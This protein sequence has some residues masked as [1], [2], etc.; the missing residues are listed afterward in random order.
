ML[1]SVLFHKSFAPL[2][3]ITHEIGEIGVSI[4][5]SLPAEAIS[6][7]IH[8]PQ[9]SDFYWQAIGPSALK[10]TIERENGHCFKVALCGHFDLKTTCVRCLNPLTMPITIDFS[11]R[12]IEKEHLGFM[13]EP[14]TIGEDGALEIDMSKDE[15]DVVGYFAGT[16]IDV[17]LILRDQIFLE[18]PDYPQCASTRCSLP[19]GNI[20]G[21]DG[22]DRHDGY[23]NNPFVKLFKKT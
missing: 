21:A 4:D 23:G 10:G 3:F 2:R 16:C 19:K 5:Q 22:L 18:V 13:G 17:G 8:E 1:S 11:I 14:D 20:L 6:A 7:L 9:K 15:E 12:M